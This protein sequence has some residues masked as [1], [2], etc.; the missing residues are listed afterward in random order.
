MFI[1]SLFS[2]FTR[3]K[4]PA[5]KFAPGLF[6]GLLAAFTLL[7][8]DKPVVGLTGLGTTLIAGGVL[9]ELNRQRIWED[10]RKQ[11]KKA[12]GLSGLWSKPDPI[13]YTINVVFLWPLIVVLGIGC[14][15]AAYVLG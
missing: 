11:Y 9:V 1:S 6:L 12:K 7:G 5:P 10:Y 15:W 4:V 13:Y 3:R 2:H 8:Q 14:L